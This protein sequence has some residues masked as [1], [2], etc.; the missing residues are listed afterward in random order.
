MRKSGDVRLGRVLHWSQS[1]LFC[2]FVDWN[3]AV[4]VIKIPSHYYNGVWV[5][6]T[7]AVRNCYRQFF[8]IILG[9]RSTIVAYH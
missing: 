6:L 3:C 8:Y 1:Q 9:F 7:K 5:F 4:V 2:Y